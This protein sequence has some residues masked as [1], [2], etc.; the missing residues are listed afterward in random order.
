MGSQ[1]DRVVTYLPAL[2]SREV[3]RF[4]NV[5]QF[6]STLGC[7]PLAHAIELPDRL[8]FDEN[9]ASCP[10]TKDHLD[11]GDSRCVKELPSPG[12]LVD[13]A[14]EVLVIGLSS[15]TGLFSHN[16]DLG[17]RR[18]FKVARLLRQAG[19]SN[20]RA[21]ALGESLFVDRAVPAEGDDFPAAPKDRRVE[22]FAC[23]SDMA[24]AKR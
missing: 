10:V 14:T 12:P 17:E 16:L 21:T 3:G 11:S 19:W 5:Q 2:E 20:V 9:D 6:A 24:I 7:S 13:E 4:I 22:I 18:A 1:P 15:S 23:S 8:F